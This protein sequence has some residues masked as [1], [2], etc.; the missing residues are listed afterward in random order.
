MIDLSQAVGERKSGREGEWERVACEESKW[1]QGEIERESKSCRRQWT[2][3]IDSHAAFF[4]LLLLCLVALFAAFARLQKATTRR[5][6]T[7]R[8]VEK[9][10][11]ASSGDFE[12]PNGAASNAVAVAA[13][14]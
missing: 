10:D 6:T 2:A 4:L 3:R 14:T 1:G 12:R 8:T 7:T 5:A 9:S 13:C 11:D